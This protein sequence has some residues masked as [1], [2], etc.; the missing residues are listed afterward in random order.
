MAFA[1][2]LVVA[3]TVFVL[4]VPAAMV[5]VLVYAA[6]GRARRVAQA[7]PLRVRAAEPVALAQEVAA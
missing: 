5:A 1:T 4:V 3:L 2:A 6:P 7:A